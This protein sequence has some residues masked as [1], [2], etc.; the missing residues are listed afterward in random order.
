MRIW[1]WTV[2]SVVRSV[3][4]NGLTSRFLAA[5]GTSRPTTV[6]AA[7][8]CRKARLPRATGMRVRNE[9][10]F[11]HLVI[12]STLNPHAG[13]PG[14]NRFVAKK[15]SEVI[16]EFLRARV[17]A[18]WFFR[19]ALEANRFQVARRVLVEQAR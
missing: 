5:G 8:I 1:G 10:S 3:R 19:E 15:S 9:S 7:E 6:A 17:T 13:A 4:T 11:F 2:R 18:L 12:R 14:V 16:G